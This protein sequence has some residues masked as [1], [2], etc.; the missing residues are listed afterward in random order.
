MLASY[1]SCYYTYL[2]SGNPL[3]R[4]HVLCNYRGEYLRKCL[5]LTAGFKAPHTGYMFLLAHIACIPLIPFGRQCPLGEI[6]GTL[7]M[8]PAA[9]WIVMTHISPQRYGAIDYLSRKKHAL[10][11]LLLLFAFLL[12]IRFL[13]FVIPHSEYSNFLC[14]LSNGKN[15]NLILVK[16]AFNK[17]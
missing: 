14:L 11:I 13:L 3:A 17:N 7:S 1:V 5:D 12:T 10:M 6:S 4:S 8:F 16:I 15:K 2:T 9:D